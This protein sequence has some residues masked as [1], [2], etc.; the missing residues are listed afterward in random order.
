MV[1]KA[2]NLA[3]PLTEA[4]APVKMRDGGFGEDSLAARSRGSVAWAKLKEPLLQ[5]DGALAVILQQRLWNPMSNI[6]TLT[7]SQHNCYP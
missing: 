4:V 2:A 6:N 3:D 1:A 7:H 5:N